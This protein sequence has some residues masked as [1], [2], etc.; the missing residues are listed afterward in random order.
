[1]KTKSSLTVLA[2]SVISLTLFG[3]SKS[4]TEKA[5]DKVTNAY[6]ISKAAVANTWSDTKEFT[7]EKSQD[8]RDRADAI[9]AD[10]DAKI[11]KVKAE[12]AEKKASASRSAAMKKLKNAQATLAEKTAALGNA[13]ADT[14]ESAKADV[15]AAG[16][17]VE[18]AYDDFV[19]DKS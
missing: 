6:E 14:W 15:I 18:A 8:F 11:E 10:A 7:F 13:T 4:N 1:M 12:Y 3:C 2:L 16:K 5:G 17:R 19:A 9:S